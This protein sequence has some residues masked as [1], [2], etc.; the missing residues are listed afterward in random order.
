MLL[1]L[2]LRDVMPR[3]VMLPPRYARWLLLAFAMLKI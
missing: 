3:D 1:L 2:R